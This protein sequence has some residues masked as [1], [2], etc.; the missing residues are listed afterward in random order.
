MAREGWHSFRYEILET[1][2][3]QRTLHHWICGESRALNLDAVSG[4]QI[5]PWWIDSFSRNALYCL[6][7]LTNP[8]VCH[9]TQE[10]VP[11]DF[12]YDWPLDVLIRVL[13]RENHQGRLVKTH[14]I[15]KCIPRMLIA[16]VSAKAS[17]ASW[18]TFYFP[19]LEAVKQTGFSRGCHNVK[20]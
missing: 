4:I 10:Q 7:M 2:E 8:S 17:L 14:L 19:Q 1:I 18:Q 16:G 11:V 6:L 15:F 9:P 13:S 20:F 12:H 3:I 5:L